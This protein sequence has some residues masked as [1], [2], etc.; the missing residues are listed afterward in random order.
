MP[1]IKPKLKVKSIPKPKP[2]LNTYTQVPYLLGGT[3][4]VATVIVGGYLGWHHFHKPTFNST[5]STTTQGVS[6][7]ASYQGTYRGATN[8][9][10]GLADVSLNV[11]GTTITGSG[12]YNGNVEGYSISAPLSIS[13]TI[14]ST[15]AVTLGISGS[16][17]VAGNTYNAGG[18]ATGQITGN[19]MTC[20]YS[21]AVTGSLSINGDITLSK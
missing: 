7:K 11:S 9:P 4:I 15:G 13:G 12:T 2:M 8:V 17:V 1:K 10:S 3:V 5:P 16:T 21:V 18:Q 14:S 6:N 19:S 20:H